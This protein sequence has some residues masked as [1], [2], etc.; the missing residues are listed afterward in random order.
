MG[1]RS[2]GR[3]EVWDAVRER[4]EKQGIQPTLAQGSEPAGPLRS[5]AEMEEIEAQHPCAA[6]D[7][8]AARRQ[9]ADHSDDA[10]DL[11]SKAG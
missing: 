3:A 2:Y 11:P 7:C 1:P 5:L 4:L 10:S 9:S 6:L 8:V